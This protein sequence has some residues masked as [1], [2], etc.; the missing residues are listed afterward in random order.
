LYLGA[1]RKIP[2]ASNVPV[3]RSNLLTVKEFPLLD[4][5]R[6]GKVANNRAIP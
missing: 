4:K 1:T 3:Q 5:K 6:E 2:D